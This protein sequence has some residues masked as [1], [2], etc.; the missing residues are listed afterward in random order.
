MLFSCHS[1]A[2]P[3]GMWFLRGILSVW[4][5]GAFGQEVQPQS[6]GDQQL[7]TEFEM[8][9]PNLDFTFYIF[10]P[11]IRATF[12]LSSAHQKSPDR[13]RLM[14]SQ[15]KEPVWLMASGSVGDYTMFP[16]SRWDDKTHFHGSLPRS[17]SQHI[18]DSLGARMLTVLLPS[19]N[20]E[21]WSPP[22]WGVADNLLTGLAGVMCS[23]ACTASS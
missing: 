19:L 3:P 6:R 10:Y 16:A 4:R 21:Q 23:M 11:C 17:G 8:D 20:K 12:I 1:T 13:A 9:I 5:S 7:G 15:S 18:R 2:D 22:R 14:Q